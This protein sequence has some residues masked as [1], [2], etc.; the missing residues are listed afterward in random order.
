MGNLG[1]KRRPSGRRFQPG[2]VRLAARAS[3]AGLLMGT[4]TGCYVYAPVGQ[5]GR[6]TTVLL[7]L[8]DRGRVGLG[9]SVG[10]SASAVEGTLTSDPDSAYALNVQAVRYLNGQ[11][12]RWTG[13]PLV[14][15]KSFVGNVRAKEFSR[16]RTFLTAAAIAA[17]AVA[18][19]VTRS[20]L[21]TGNVEREPNPP[22]PG[23]ET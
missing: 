5:P 9:E 22:G 14:V 20:V 3:L 21:G 23:P 16:S 12:N 10:P 7:D 15:S 6:G 17:G 13:E 2:I 8:N 11:N 18:I 4:M 19:I 1:G